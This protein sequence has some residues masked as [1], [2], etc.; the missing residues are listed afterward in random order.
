[1]RTDDV[2]E[3]VRPCQFEKLK[4]TVVNELKSDQEPKYCL[5]L[6]V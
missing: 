2:I 3:A 6:C 4:A 5:L 1:M